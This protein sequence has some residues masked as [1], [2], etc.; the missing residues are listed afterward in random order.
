MAKA[1][2]SNNPFSGIIGGFI[3]IIVGTC[4]LWWN[5]G[6]NVKNIKT[7]KEVSKEVVDISSSSVNSKYE[8]KLVALSGKMVTEDEILT[9]S[10]FLISAKTPK[11]ERFVEM[12]QWVEDE[13]TD[14]DNNTTY[15]YSKKWSEEVINSN[16][17][18]KKGHDNP[19]SMEYKS[20]SFVASGVKVGAYNLSS[21][22]INKL[23]ASDE[24][25]I[26]TKDFPN[27]Y[28]LS[29][30]Y[31]T[32]STDLDNPQIGDIR[33]SWKYNNWDD[34]SVLAVVS[35]NSFVDFH[36]KSGKTVN[37]VEKGL[38]KSSDFTTMIQD[39][40]N[41]L[42]WILRIV[43]LVIII[44]GYLSIVSLATKLASFVPFLGGLVGG[45]ISLIAALIGI[46]HT[47]IVIA[48]A[49]I[50]F[51]PILGIVLLAVAVVLIILVKKLI[52]KNKKDNTTQPQVDQ[53]AQPVVEQTTPQPEETQPVDYQNTMNNVQPQEEQ[54]NN[55]TANN[56]TSLTDLYNQDNNK[57][58]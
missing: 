18:A 16:T 47:L 49:W 10:T 32:N 17:F 31:I 55:T 57:N 19:N 27:G 8:G 2:K 11:L 7:L 26:D 4:L 6:N 12:Y 23:P 46:I 24:L 14:S 41:A 21:N 58:Q 9:D 36:S 34:A 56:Q 25:K 1:G 35:G 38:L 44:F 52:D 37:R 48:I 5:E 30:N 42:K 39:E 40:N 28:F 54:N 53:N 45:V 3:L 13:S 22:Q 51:R 15:S 43:G 33:I 29:N 20:E 50:R